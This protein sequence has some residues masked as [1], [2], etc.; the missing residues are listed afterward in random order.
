MF[1][2]WILGYPFLKKYR[3]VFDPEKK[4][5]GIPNRNFIIKTK[6]LNKNQI[7][8]IFLSLIIIF[9]LLIFIKFCLI[10]KNKINRKIR[11]NEL[12]ENYEYLSNQNNNIEYKKI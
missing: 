6:N 9:M 2:E 11:A 8:I 12:E 10:L 7:I 3:F 5:I 4:I 1:P